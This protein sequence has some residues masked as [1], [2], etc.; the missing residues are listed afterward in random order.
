MKWGDSRHITIIW[1][2]WPIMAHENQILAQEYTR[3]RV[4]RI[5]GFGLGFRVAKVYRVWGLGFGA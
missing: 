5:L 1:G 2:L 4:Y 3:L